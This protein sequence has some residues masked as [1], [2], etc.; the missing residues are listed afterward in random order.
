MPLRAEAPST[1]WTGQSGSL[2]HAGVR[3]W[4]A[5]LG[6]ALLVGCAAPDRP[7]PAAWT[8][9]V[10]AQ[11]GPLHA[12]NGM[13]FGPDGRLYVVSASSAEVAALDAE[14]GAVLERWGPEEG[15]QG[16]DDLIFGPD[17]S[18]YWTEFAFGDV[19]RRT[20]DGTTTVI[21]SPG[22]GVNPITVG[23]PPPRGTVP[24][25]PKTACPPG[26]C[27]NDPGPNVRCRTERPAT[28]RRLPAVPV[29]P[30]CGN[31]RCTSNAASRAARSWHRSP[32]CGRRGQRP[33]SRSGSSSWCRT[34]VGSGDVRR[35]P[36]WTE[37]ELTD[38]TW[39]S[40]AMRMKSEAGTSPRQA[41]RRHGVD[42][43]ATRQ[44]ASAFCAS[45]RF[46]P[47]TL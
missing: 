2:P 47:G 8:V 7:E 6:V 18:L 29:M 24:G 19:A 35:A 15:V 31:K 32:R 28:E 16:P 21:A 43:D 13:H 9:T 41:A 11:G 39:R 4:S 22:P 1:T 42:S 37:I 33:W 38:S 10:L 20:P 23:R 3:V 14:S 26:G 5:G 30:Y 45:S 17:G 46:L 25:T 34:A 44:A 12:T 27:P 36:S 40:P